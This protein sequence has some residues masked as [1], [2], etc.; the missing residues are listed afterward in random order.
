[1]YSD[2][3]LFFPC[4]YTISDWILSSITIDRLEIIIGP[5]PFLM[6]GMIYYKESIENTGTCPAYPR[7]KKVVSSGNKEKRTS[8]TRA[9]FLF[10]VPGKPVESSDSHR[11]SPLF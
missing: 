1:M 9:D 2:P 3:L 4:D 10:S 8:W 6:A 7:Q 5:S 11:G